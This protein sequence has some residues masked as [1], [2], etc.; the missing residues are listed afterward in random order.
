[1]R[2]AFAY[3]LRSRLYRFVTC[4]GWVY[5]VSVSQRRASSQ[6][7]ARSP[8]GEEK[9]RQTNLRSYGLCTPI[10]VRGIGRS[11]AIAD[12]GRRGWDKLYARIEFVRFKDS[13]PTTRALRW[14]GSDHIIAASGA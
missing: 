12:I 9:V 3:E 8:K 5:S 13:L 11:P 10:N 6:A 4:L 14:Y 1:M 2:T 7:E